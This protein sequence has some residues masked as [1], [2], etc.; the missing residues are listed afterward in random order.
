MIVHSYIQTEGGMGLGDF[1]RGSLALHQVCH[2]KRS[3][4]IITFK[5]HPISE[6]II[7]N[8][9]PIPTDL[10]IHNLN[11]K[12]DFIFKLKHHIEL[13]RGNRRLRDAHMGLHCNTF[14]FYPI[15]DIT[16]KFVSN[17]FKPNDSLNAAIQAA[18]PKEDYEVIHIRTGDLVAYNTAIN[19]TVAYNYNRL[20]KRII[21]AVNEIKSQSSNKFIIMCDSDKVK[22]T[23]SEI[24]GLVPTSAESVH[25]N[26]A[27]DCDAKRVKDTL[28]DFFL[29][30]HAKVIHQ[31]SV[32]GWGSTFSNCAHWIYDVPLKRYELQLD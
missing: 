14:P 1:L 27:K 2:K 4:F 28:V 32:H 31:F 26:L 19:T 17:S 15:H 9:T 5:D 12:A 16:K 29:L 22:E 11:N 30:T 10:E 21:I 18:K 8:D 13:F 23:L 24:C 25:F 7:G 20:L 6:F 3:Q